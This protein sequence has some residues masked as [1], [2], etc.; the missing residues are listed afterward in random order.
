M[1]A[2]AL[3]L[4]ADWSVQASK[5]WMTIARRHGA[6]WLV[7]APEPVGPVATLLERLRREAAD[8][9]APG[10]A[11]A[12]GIDCPIGLPRA[13]IARH[14]GLG[15]DFRDFLS[16]LGGGIGRVGPHFLDVCSALDEV[17]MARPFYPMHGRRGM[18]RAT[19]AEALGL[20][21]AAALMR[22]CDRATSGRAAGA[23]MFWTLGANQSGKAAIAAWRDLVLPALSASPDK[24]RLWPFDGTLAACA[25]DAAALPGLVTLAETYP[26]EALHQ[27]GL[28][29]ARSGQAA[30][31]RGSK[32]RQADR[33]ALGPG[34]LALL[35]RFG[36]VADARLRALALDGFGSDATGED[37]FDS[38]TG[39]L[40]VLSVLA[41]DR[42]DRIPDDAWVQL[43]EGWV[44]GQCPDS[45]SLAA[46]WL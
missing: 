43:W 34:L 24:L 44:L 29:L 45:G 20:P 33:A 14:P 31:L 2:Y 41:G 22:L 39:L 7:T 9:K 25:A 36:A 21:D 28:R 37:R 1:Q 11:V 12:F 46:A 27:L 30:T 42:G 6:G 18:S 17:G 38:M 5:R 32:R 3:A 23:P 35:S 16:R 8:T 40:C 19:H 26:A 10:D 15:R 13:F 4:H